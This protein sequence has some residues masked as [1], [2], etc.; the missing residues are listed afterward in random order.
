MRVRVR[1]LAVRARTLVQCKGV[2][3][4]VMESR[5]GTFMTGDKSPSES[6][7]PSEALRGVGV[8]RSCAPGVVAALRGALQKSVLVH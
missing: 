1:L 5:F 8:C 6:R 2:V 7:S 4:E 3:G